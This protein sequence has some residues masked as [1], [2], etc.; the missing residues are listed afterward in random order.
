MERE[1][2][3][4]DDLIDFKKQVFTL[5]MKQLGRFQGYVPAKTDLD[6]FP[7]DEPLIINF[8]GIE[9][10]PDLNVFKIEVY[11]SEDDVTEE[12]AKD[13]YR[14]KFQKIGGIEI[15]DIMTFPLNK[16]AIKH[17]IITVFINICL[18]KFFKKLFQM[19]YK[20]QS[21]ISD[22]ERMVNYMFVIKDAEPKGLEFIYNFDTFFMGMNQDEVQY[23]GFLD[24]EK[25][26]HFD[27]RIITEFESNIVDR[28]TVVLSSSEFRFEIDSNIVSYPFIVKMIEEKLV[29]IKTR[30]ITA[31]QIFQKDWVEGEFKNEFNVKAGMIKQ[32]IEKIK[33]LDIAHNSDVIYSSALI[34]Q[35]HP[36]HFD[37]TFGN[38]T[39]YNGK[40]KFNTYFTIA[41]PDQT[42]F[43]LTPLIQALYDQSNLFINRYC[44]IEMLQEV[45]KDEAP[46]QSKAFFYYL[47]KIITPF[48]INEFDDGGD[49]AN[50]VI[51]LN[52]I[53]IEGDCDICRK[54]VIY[55]FVKGTKKRVRALL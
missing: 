34:L 21:F 31:H 23:R 1:L 45:Y 6:M 27:I 30:I 18:D 9:K 35:E 40:K 4:G 12:N 36:G 26:E 25:A 16:N 2:L 15:I 20:L 42:N 7:E 48:I 51:K 46:G 28:I 38:E 29:E 53:E 43:K 3:E 39:D 52:E 8:N 32:K 37:I 5:V 11:N 14:L 22:V 33:E 17:E 50:A 54:Y 44:T 13:K 24:K 10:Y 55:D 47:K 49:I 41:T 19:P